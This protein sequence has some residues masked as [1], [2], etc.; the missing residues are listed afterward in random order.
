MTDVAALEKT[1]GGS[2]SAAG[3]YK[4]Y[5]MDQVHRAALHNTGSM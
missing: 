1:G 5:N 4:Y 3:Q 2:S